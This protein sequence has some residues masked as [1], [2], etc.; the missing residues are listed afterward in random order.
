MHSPSTC[1][2]D[3]P[4]PVETPYAM[5]PHMRTWQ[6][7][8]P[9]LTRDQDFNH[10]I[11]QKRRFYS[12]VYGNNARPG[13]LKSA[14]DT[15][16]SFDPTAPDLP[17]HDLMFHMTMNLQ[18]DFVVWA[19]RLD[20]GELSAQILSVCLPSGWHPYEKV[21]MSFRDIHTVV[22]DNDLIM[23]GADAISRLIATRGPFVRHVWSISNTGDLNRQPDRCPSWQD[24]TLDDM[25]FRCERQVTVPVAGEAALFL[26]RVYVRPLRE[27]CQDP[28]KQHRI[29]DSVNSMSDAVLDYKGFRYVKEYLNQHVA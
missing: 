16:R 24:Q 20:D 12:P 6:P 28:E 9:I 4:F 22:A 21:N 29:L 2:D 26:I 1:L 23:A 13:L 11:E 8:E 17:D 25:W 10:Y 3:I 7:G 14:M 15:L 27:I 19:P 5:R 18:E